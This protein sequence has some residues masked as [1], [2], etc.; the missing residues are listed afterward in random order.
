MVLAT[1][2]WWVGGRLSVD[3]PSSSLRRAADARIVDVAERSAE[4][5]YTSAIA[6]LEALTS[7][8]RASLDPEMVSV[9]DTGMTAIDT[10]I[11]QSR[12]ALEDADSAISASAAAAVR[13][14]PI[15]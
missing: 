3:T 14:I 15:N 7:A 1:G 5:H 4:A 8:E 10:A 9:L 2:L 6:S 11:D 12:A 13:P